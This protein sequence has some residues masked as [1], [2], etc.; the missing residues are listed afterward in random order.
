MRVPKSREIDAKRE[1]ESCLFSWKMDPWP[2]KGRLLG[3]PGAFLGESK[4]RHLFD[5]AP[6]VGKVGQNQ[7]WPAQWLQK[8]LRA[9]VKE[10][11]RRHQVVSDE[12]PG[13]G[14]PRVRVFD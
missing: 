12:G 13:Q 4:K 1:P 8:S 14:W 10:A 5:V 7:S 6:G 11:P 3:C 9:G 2:S